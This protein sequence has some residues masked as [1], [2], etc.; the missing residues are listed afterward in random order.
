[1]QDVNV[2]QVSMLYPHVTR[3]VPEL[4]DLWLA[5]GMCTVR[6]MH[7]QQLSWSRPWVALMCKSKKTVYRKHK[8]QYRSRQPAVLVCDVGQSRISNEVAE[9]QPVETIWCDDRRFW[10]KIVS[11]ALHE[12]AFSL[13]VSVRVGGDMSGVAAFYD[14]SLQWGSAS[15]CWLLALMPCFVSLLIHSWNLFC[16]NASHRYPAI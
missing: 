9:S 1:M 7:F 2:L 16:S 13:C 11:S 10:R 5:D 12:N 14:G 15:N 6:A 4:N 3:V 8:F